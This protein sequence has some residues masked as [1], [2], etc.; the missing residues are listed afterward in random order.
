MRYILFLALLLTPI[1]VLNAQ[2][3]KNLDQP[4]NTWVKRSPLKS[5]PLSPMLGYEGSFG[6]DPKA[7]LLIRW[8]G[9]NQG[10]GGEQ[11]AETWTFDPV[12]AKWT[13]K[14]PNTSPPGQCCA[15]QNVFD[16][17][18]GR[19]FRFSGFSGNHGWHWFRENY[20]N[21][22]SVWSYD[23]EKNTWRD[24]RTVPAPRPAGLRCASWDSDHQVIGLFGG[25]GASDGTIVYDPY[26]NEWTRMF[27]KKE[28]AGR[29]AGNMAYDKVMKKHI[30]FGAQFADDPHTWA[31]DL[32]N[33]EWTDLKP[34][35]QP[36]TDKNDAVLAYDEH[37]KVIVASLRV[38]GRTKGDEDW[39]YETWSFDGAK[40][41]WQKM[42][43]NVEPPGGGQRRRIMAA[44][45]DQNVILMEN[46]VNPPQKVPDVDRE[47]QI[48]T[49]RYAQTAPDATAATPKAKPR[50]R[51]RLV[52]D[53]IASV[54]SL[55]KVTLTWPAAKEADVV[56]YHV[57]R[58][59][60]EIFSE[61][62][63]YRLRW[64][65]ASFGPPAVGA[66]KSIGRFEKLTKEPIKQP[67]YADTGIDLS[68]PVAVKD[69]IFRHRF[70][71]SQINDDGAPYRHA[72]YAYRVRAVNRLGVESGPGPYAL[73]IPSA[74]QWVFSKEEGTTCH[75][76]WEKNAE[77]GI[78]G[79]HVYRMESPRINGPGQ[80][81][82]RLTREPIA[83]PR[84]VDENA[85]KD[86]A[87]YWIVAVDGLGQEGYPSAPVWFERQYKKY[88][89]PFTGAWHQ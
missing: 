55:T 65:T 89:V 56:G 21:N 82:Q 17:V 15:Q 63:I 54:H 32:S 24:M 61:D 88:Y 36:P 29:S 58:A 51:P 72:V 26:T 79:Y 7:K 40:N 19:F 68:K 53:V 85:G 4:P 33:N 86:T 62:Q 64:D 20:L 38:F 43:P 22:A 28:P 16:P 3:T 73:T 42:N 70:A 60:V 25:E 39:H 46:Y 2:S 87:R 84:Y 13:L 5:A 37:N 8:A 41:T 67:T 76:K 23:L 75:V 59:L 9:H 27:P 30:L 49:Y 83:S 44:I 66:I 18:A 57:E 81:V 31:Y 48:W 1:G 11:N 80:T 10:G 47:Q 12:T 35:V 77:H 52:E 74:P 78:A 14:E 45:P 50:N 69:E 71:V 6:Y 34:A